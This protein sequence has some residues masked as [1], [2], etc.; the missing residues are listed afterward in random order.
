LLL[1][2]GAAVSVLRNRRHLHL[3]LEHL[4]D[5]F[6]LPA[7]HFQHALFF[8]LYKRGVGFR[9]RGH[10]RTRRQAFR[11]SLPAVPAAAA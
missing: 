5:F 11:L 9:L 6:L 4:L 1:H 3:K 2:L 8:H 10:H 7:L